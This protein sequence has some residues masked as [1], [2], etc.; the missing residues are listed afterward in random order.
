VTRHGGHCGFIAGFS[1]RS[2]AEDWVA[3]RLAE[4]A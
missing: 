3:A 2:W 1:L 4:F